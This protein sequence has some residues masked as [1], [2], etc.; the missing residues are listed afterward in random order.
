MKLIII[1]T[2]MA[3]SFSI[4]GCSEQDQQAKTSKPDVLKTQME[5]LDKAKQVERTLQDAAVQQRKAIDE[6][7]QSQGQ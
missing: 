3:L 7:T 1:M 6:S 4:Y 5:A 2:A